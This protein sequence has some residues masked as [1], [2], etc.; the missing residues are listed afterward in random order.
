M[1]RVKHFFL[2]IL[3]VMSINAMGHPM[4]HSVFTL[5]PHTSFVEGQL[6]IPVK[7][8]QLAVPFSILASDTTLNAETKLELE[9]YILHHLHLASQ[10][11]QWKVE[12]QE[13]LLNESEQSS[14]GTYEELTFHLKLFPPKGGSVNS[15]TLDYDGVIHQVVTHKIFVKKKN[16]WRSGAVESSETLLGVIELDIANN[17]IHPLTLTLEK[18]GWWKGFVTMVKLGIHHIAEGADHLLFLLVLLLVAPLSLRNKKWIASGNMVQSLKNILRISLAFTVGHSLTLVLATFHWIKLPPNLVEIFIALSI[19]ITA[20]HALVPFFAQKEAWI[21]L[22]FGLV[23]GMAFSNLIQD[24]QLDSLASLIGLL[25]FNVG[26]ELMQIFV[27]VLVM[28]WLLFL[29]RYKTYT[30]V[31][32]G[33]A[34]FAIVASVVWGAERINAHA[35]FASVYMETIAK[36]AIVVVAILVAL[37]ILSSVWGK[38]VSAA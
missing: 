2:W 6:Q 12:V 5:N 20:V 15:F 19:L 29:S 11:Q 13:V 14:S 3:F 10:Q 34:S 9:E 7:E 16:D 27:I 1:K 31:R 21:A 36:H 33:G 24:L 18:Q 4:P 26:I 17:T 32:I 30:W 38:K 22:A 25:G 23:H 37:S 8:L 28:P 35:N